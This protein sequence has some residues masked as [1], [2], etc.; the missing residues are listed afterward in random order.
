[1]QIFADL[2]FVYDKFAVKPTMSFA[3]E[4]FA[5]ETRRARLPVCRLPLLAS[6]TECWGVAK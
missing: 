1:L 2:H 4:S 5:S 3:M 6:R